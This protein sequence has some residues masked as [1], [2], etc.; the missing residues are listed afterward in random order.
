MNNSSLLKLLKKF[1]KQEL[2]DFNNF[3]KSPFFN[4]NK[5]L[6]SLFEY[7]R[8]QYPLFEPEK[9]EKQYI[10]RKIFGKAE[11]NDGFFRV[12]MS[13]LQTLAEDYLT[14]KGMLREPHVKKK[15]LLTELNRLGE[16]KL[17]ER[18]LRREM[19]SVDIDSAMHPDDYLGLYNLAFFRRYFYSTKFSVTKS[20]KPDTWIYD[21]QKFLIYHFLL[22]LLADHF[23]HLNQQ[24]LINY[25][26]KLYFLDEVSA[27]LE[28][29]K[30]FLESPVLNIT[31]LRVL[32]M[33]NNRMEDF[34]RLKDSFIAIFDKL[35]RKD[36][37]NTVSII[38][39]YCYRNYYIT[40]N[41][42]MMKERMNVL[43]FALHKGL[44]SFEENDYFDS[45]W[46]FNILSTGFELGET[47]WPEE[48]LEEFTSKADPERVNFLEN[49]GRAMLSF[50]RGSFE[51]ALEYLSQ[52]RHFS[53][54]A[55]KFNFKILQLLVY[56]ELKMFDQ[57]ES[58]ADSF[59]H[60]LQNDTVISEFNKTL[61]RNFYALYYRL[62]RINTKPGKTDKAKLKT[63]IL[64]SKYTYHQKWLLNKVDEL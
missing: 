38:L 3:V 30:E 31:Y 20:S 40:G 64:Q 6:I 51:E 9:L 62:L 22:R 49:M 18:I 27:F 45:Q 17:A 16:N 29:N 19:D 2:K 32:L 61:F 46:F 39:N 42:E 41:E 13:N 23:Y 52:I 36:N 14:Y 37:F 10:S 25:A 1:D 26:P 55:E 48:F 24:N 54:A 34:F 56:Y 44:H 53:N 50:N 4:S 35:G 47:D 60:V 15:Y 7:I 11:Y 33:K 12:L 21:E 58:S 59:R 57:A 43:K 8:K 63:E 28:N 5:A